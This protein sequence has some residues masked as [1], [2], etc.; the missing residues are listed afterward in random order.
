MQLARVTR[1]K[2]VKKIGP[3][4]W[5]R[6]NRD[7]EHHDA[8]VPSQDIWKVPMYA[9]IIRLL[10]FVLALHDLVVLQTL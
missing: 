2:C 7:R 5:G 1:E 6:G 10:I 4:S 8:E 3:V 9:Y